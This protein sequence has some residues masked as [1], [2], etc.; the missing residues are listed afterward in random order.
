M[1]FF[2]NNNIVKTKHE[3][4]PFTGKWLDS[5]GEPPTHGDWIIYGTSGSG[6]TSF[7]L[8]MA[9]YMTNFEKVL[10]WSMEQG[11]SKT[12]QKLW[13]REKMPECGN[14]IT[15]ADNETTFEEIIKKMTQRKGFD[16]L[17]IDSLTTLR[18][19]TEMVDNEPVIKNFGAV[20]FERFR[21][22]T[23]RKLRI[24]I[25]HEKNGIPDTSVGDYIMKLSDL[26]M[27]CEGFKVMTNSRAGDKMEDF[28]IWRKGMNEYLGI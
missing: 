7:A 26:K 18:Y 3:T 9:K 28:V 10:Y 4:I 22:R 14:R 13:N 24:W 1:T 15:V 2:S 20:A 12:F 16:I 21:K 17:I 27:R 25:S 8:Q 19:Y 11:N 6:K 23:K 5:F